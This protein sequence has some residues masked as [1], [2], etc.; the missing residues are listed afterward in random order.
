MRHDD[1]VQMVRRL[2]DHIDDGTTTY[3]DKIHRNPVSSY[4]CPDRLAREVETA[5]RQWPVLIGMSNRIASAGDYVTEDIAGVPTLIC[6][7]REGAV[8]A[9]VNIC[10]HRGARLVDGCGS[11][12][13]FTCPY[14]AW[15]YTLDGKLQTIP[16]GRDFESVDK[17]AHG[18]KELHAIEKYGLIFVQPEGAMDIDAAL[19][20]MQRDLAAYGFEG[21]HHY[22]SLT[23]RRQ[24]NWKLSPETFMEGYHLQYLHRDSVGPIFF[25]NLMAFDA[26]GRNSRLT[27]PRRRILEL[28]DRAPDDWR[29]IPETAIIYTFFP[30][31]T[32][33][34]QAGHVEMWRAYPDGAPDRCRVEISVYTPEPVVSEKAKAYYEKNIDLAILTVDGEDFPLS[35]GIQHGHMSAMQDHVTYGRNEPALIHFCTTM[36]SAIS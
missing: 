20:G 33:V 29:L 10:S 4:T 8:R 3:A 22:R 24:M 16:S 9:F 35:E 31:V 6:R 25:S 14:H 19:G 13:R 11:A 7:D 18:L 32:F 17:A 1:Q 34:V 15:T 23:I 26:F 36:N 21:F 5:F 27:L 28:K 2:F 30:N 12:R